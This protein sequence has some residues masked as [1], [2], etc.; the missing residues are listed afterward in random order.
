MSECLFKAR[1]GTQCL[2]PNRDKLYAY[3]S[4]KPMSVIGQFKTCVTFRD[5]TV[6]TVFHVIPG[7]HQ[8]LL[9]KDTSERLGLLRVG[10]PRPGASPTWAALLT[11]T[12]LCLED[13]A[14]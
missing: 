10:P 2:L 4:G 13:L 7:S 1:F 8:S 12:P 9:G 5:S 11:D 14:S 6:Q 3:G